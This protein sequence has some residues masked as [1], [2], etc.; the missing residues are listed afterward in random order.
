LVEEGRVD[1]A[2]NG[3]AVHD[4][5]DAHAEHGEEVDV[6]DGSWFVHEPSLYLFE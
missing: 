2:D 5:A 4:E 6:V 3:L 1:D